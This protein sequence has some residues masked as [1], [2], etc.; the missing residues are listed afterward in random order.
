[1]KTPFEGFDEEGLEDN[2]DRK[3]T[4]IEKGFVTTLIVFAKVV[5]W[6]AGRVKTYG[7]I[8]A[9]IKFIHKRADNLDDSMEDVTDTTELL[10]MTVD[11]A[12]EAGDEL[13]G[14]KGS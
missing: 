6:K 14:Y 13:K 5:L 12:Q 1:M 8:Y 11:A 2:K 10:K 7:D 3:L 4:L 9:L